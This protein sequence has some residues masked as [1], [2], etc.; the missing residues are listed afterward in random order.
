[1]RT[2]TISI[3]DSE[4]DAVMRQ[5][6]EWQQRQAVRF[7][8]IDPLIFPADAPLTPEEWEHELQRALASGK[9]ALTKEQA[10]AR[11]GL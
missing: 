1:M 8:A 3:L 9:V 2:I 4:E 10:L 11:F 6:D 7:E 5:I